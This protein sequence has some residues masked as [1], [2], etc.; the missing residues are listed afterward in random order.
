MINMLVRLQIDLKIL[1]IFKKCLKNFLF[2][3]AEYLIARNWMNEW[4]K[5]LYFIYIDNAKQ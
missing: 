2:L 5:Y 1:D 3:F 4:V